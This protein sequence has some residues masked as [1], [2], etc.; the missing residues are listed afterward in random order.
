[1]EKPYLWVGEYRDHNF[2]IEYFP[3][4]GPREVSVSLGIPGTEEYLQ[5]WCSANDVGTTMDR[6]IRRE[7]HHSL[8]QARKAKETG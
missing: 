1:M 2:R 5:A 3:Q 6:L 4:C 7:P 8:G